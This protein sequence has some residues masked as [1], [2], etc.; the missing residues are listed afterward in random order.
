M[1]QHIAA[2]YHQEEIVRVFR[3]FAYAKLL[4]TQSRVENYRGL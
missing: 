2:V 1:K 3:S 4:A